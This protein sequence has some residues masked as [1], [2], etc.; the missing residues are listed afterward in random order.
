MDSQL[1]MGYLPEGVLIR[2]VGRGTMRESPAF[3]AAAESALRGGR[4][5]ADM[6]SCEYLD[7]TF[8]GCLI[9]VQKL[10]EGR[11]STNFHIAA[12]PAVRVKLFGLT[13]LDQYFDFIDQRLKPTTE[14]VEIECDELDQLELGRHVLE[15][16]RRLAER[17]GH[18]AEA[19]RRAC[20]R[21]S[22][23]LNERE[24]HDS[25]IGL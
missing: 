25:R 7:S 9:G 13:S 21:L 8:L 5:V 3:R 4:L 23:E 6:E 15:C 16:H 10:A 11:P 24:S 17:G 22:A 12:E 1:L 18:D 20:D 2:V 14:M 19:F